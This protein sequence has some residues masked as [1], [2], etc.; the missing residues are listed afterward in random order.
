MRFLPQ[1]DIRLVSTPVSPVPERKNRHHDA[2]VLC[3]IRGGFRGLSGEEAVI[4]SG[5]PVAQLL[6]CLQSLDL[7]SWQS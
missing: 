2:T 3:H 1:P 7:G 5:G 4:A 6:S